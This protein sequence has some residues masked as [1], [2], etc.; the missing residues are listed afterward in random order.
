MPNP[1]T[2][3]WG[4]ADV[5]GALVVA[6]PGMPKVT[7]D[8]VVVAATP[9][10]AAGV[11]GSELPAPTAFTTKVLVYRDSSTLFRAVCRFASR[12]LGV[13]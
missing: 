8:G 9:P 2:E 1:S 3:D 10:A 12:L 4:R 5:N 6:T 7:A 13:A 11:P